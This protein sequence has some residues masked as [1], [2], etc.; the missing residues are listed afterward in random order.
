MQEYI[1]LESISSKHDIKINQ[2]YKLRSRDDDLLYVFME[3]ITCFGDDEVNWIY[4]I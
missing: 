2:E 3:I 1:F 4:W